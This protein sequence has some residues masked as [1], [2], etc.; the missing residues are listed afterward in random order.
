MENPGQYREVLVKVV[1]EDDA[2]CSDEC[3]HLEGDDDFAI[4][5][6]GSLILDENTGMFTRHCE[7]RMAE[8]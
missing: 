3:P 4:C 5:I 2:H 8:R 1:V 6:F 7:C